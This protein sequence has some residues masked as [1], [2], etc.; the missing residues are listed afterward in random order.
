MKNKLATVLFISLLIL[1]ASPVC[2]FAYDIN[3]PQD[4][5][6]SDSFYYETYIF[7]EPLGKGNF[8]PD[9]MPDF[10]SKRNTKT[11]SKIVYCKNSYGKTMWYVKVTGVFKYG[12]GH[13][14]CTSASCDAVSK[15]KLW[16]VHNKSAKASGNKAIGQATGKHHRNGSVVDTVTKTVTIKCTP[17]GHFS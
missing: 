3:S 14:S 11:K 8:F 16:T 12:N 13:S 7:D 6:N 4:S 15:N 9:T 2:I 5:D 10:L 1:A 17:S